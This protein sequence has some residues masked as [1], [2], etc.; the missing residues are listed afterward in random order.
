MYGWEG[1]ET[2]SF[3]EDEADGSSERDRP[4]RESCLCLE[5]GEPLESGRS[6]WVRRR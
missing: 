3:E 5:D 4:W 6:G 2:G 1:S